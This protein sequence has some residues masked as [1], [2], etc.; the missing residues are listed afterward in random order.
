VSKSEAKT[1][2]ERRA[3]LIIKYRNLKIEREEREGDVITYYLSRGDS[4]YVLRILIGQITIGIA[5]VRELRDTIQE[6]GADKG[7]LVGDG[8][9]TYSARS[10]APG[11]GVELIPATLPVFDIFEHM[12]VPRA[13]I[14][15]EEEKQKLVKT[16]HAQLYQFPWIKADD[17][18]AIILGA[19]PGD[20]IRI[21]TESE[22]A[23]VAESY[24][25]V[26]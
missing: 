3:A 2:E 9:Y 13:E 25:Y 20:V 4:K 10:S 24:R 17:P 19:E 15:S 12:L 11:L 26:V 7:I 1:V 8:K 16:Y 22:T 14:V 23:G 21:M 5:F 18:V 6:E